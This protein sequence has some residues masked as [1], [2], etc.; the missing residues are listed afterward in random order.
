[1]ITNG[2]ATSL[3]ENFAYSQGEVTIEGTAGKEMLDEQRNFHLKDLAASHP[4]G[5]KLHTINLSGII[6]LRGLVFP[7]NTEFLTPVRTLRVVNTA[8]ESKDDLFATIAQVMPDLEEL[9][10]TGSFLIHLAG[11]DKVIANGLKSLRLKGGRIEDFSAM[12]TVA[13]QVRDGSWSGKLRLEELDV[14]DN[15][16]AKLIPA[17]G[18]LPLRILLVE[19][20]AFRIP[21]RRHWEKGKRLQCILKARDIPNDCHPLLQEP[22]LCS[23]GSEMDSDTSYMQSLYQSQSNTSS[24]ETIQAASYE[25][26]I[27]VQHTSHPM[28]LHH[29]YR[30]TRSCPPP[31]TTRHQNRSSTPSL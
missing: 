19:N 26:K 29:R 8:L 10:L 25:R 20:N 5:S 18:C 21:N 31:Q 28:F 17:I 3:P 22:A 13:E 23:L 16:I 30:S 24:R 1:M 6:P 7:T 27:I 12:E 11:I 4:P 15:N 2:L 9:D 14:R